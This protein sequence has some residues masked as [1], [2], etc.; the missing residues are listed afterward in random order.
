[1]SLKQ[2]GVRFRPPALPLSPE[3]EWVLRAA[4]GPVDGTSE[5]IDRSNGSLLE[6]VEPRDAVELARRLYLAP[7]IAAR[8]GRDRLAGT[9]GSGLAQDLFRDQMETLYRE[10]RLAELCTTLA[11]VAAEI[12]TPL[13]FLKFAA[14]Q[15]SGYLA[16]GSRDAVDAD[17]LVPR[18]RAR[19]L[20][21]A[22]LERGFRDK[23][24]PE[25]EHH[26]PAIG[27]SKGGVEVHH[28]ILGLRL[29]DEAFATAEEL[30]EEGLVE[31]C[32]GMPGQSMVPVPAVLAAHA[33]L[34]GVSQHGDLPTSYPMPRMISDLMDL[35]IGEERGRGLLGQALP[36][37]ADEVTPGEIRAIE[38]LCSR[39]AG[40]QVALDQMGQGEGALLRHVVL[41]LLDATYERSLKL[42]LLTRRLRDGGRRF[43]V[44]R[45]A[46]EAVALTRGQIDSVYGP[47]RSLWGYAAKRL[48]R[49]FDLCARLSCYV[50]SL[51]RVKTRGLVRATSADG[52]GRT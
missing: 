7:R 43:A 6:D 29:A 45:R 35:G 46:W 20:Q 5:W 28:S 14:L 31:P 9:L 41:G 38:G 36:W 44:L 32:R 27:G 21:D 18:A 34:H 50:A 4:W 15:L 2:D 33:V 49:P 13:V 30:L 1:M 17:V 25:H 23:G 19:D 24:F 47:S 52:S 39:L 3:L 37:I 22:L 48:W 11:K 16:P 10:A 26:L 51:C 8:L 12:S 42:R 40:G